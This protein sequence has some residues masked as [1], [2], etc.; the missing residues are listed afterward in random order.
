MMEKILTIC[1]PTYNMEALLPRCLDSFII[2]EEFMNRLE[3]IVVNDGSK[4]RS[5]EIAHQYEAKYPNSFIVIDKPNG[6]YGSCVNA[7]LKIARGKYFRIC[8]ADDHYV[9]QNLSA[10]I[11]FLDR[12]NVDVIFSPYATLDISGNIINKTIT[13]INLIG[14]VYSID[15]LNWENAELAHFRAMHCMATRTQTLLDNDY[16]QTEGIS[17]TDM[18]LV[19]YSCLYSTNCS[20]FADIIYCYYLGR[21]GQSMSKESMIKTHMHFYLNAEK[22]LTDYIFIVPPISEN[23]RKLLLKSIAIELSSY[24]NVVLKYILKSSEKIRLYNNLI[25]VGKKS[26]IRCNIEDYI[27]NNK[28]FII[29]RKYHIHPY[30]IYLSQKLSSIFVK[31]TRLHN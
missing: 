25:E 14:N 29:W 21:D 16:Y 2:E 20:F 12:I 24:I 1:V 30:A 13:P 19:F 28:P 15:D 11:S 26:T 31:K 5:S 6:N 18:Q 8:D 23:R 22:M 4:D 17:Y 27:D 9:Q 10:Y 7:A 3:I